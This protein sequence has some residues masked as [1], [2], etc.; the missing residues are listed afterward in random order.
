VNKVIDYVVKK[1]SDENNYDE[2]VS[3][4]IPVYL[5]LPKKPARNQ[6]GCYLG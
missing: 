1:R 4:E 3:T 2:P 6:S 5:V